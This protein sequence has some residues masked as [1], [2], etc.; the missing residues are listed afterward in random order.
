METPPELVR[1]LE[2]D[3]DPDVAM[4]GVDEV[5]ELLE[6]ANRLAYLN[7]AGQQLLREAP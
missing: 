4:L 1:I 6:T 7:V 3:P 2:T 5:I